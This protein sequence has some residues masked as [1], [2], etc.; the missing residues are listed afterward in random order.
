MSRKAIVFFFVISLSEKVT[1]WIVGSHHSNTC[2]DVETDVH[3]EQTTEK[4][5]QVSVVH[6]WLKSI[7]NQATAP[8]YSPY[9]ETAKYWANKLSRSPSSI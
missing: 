4:M 5:N 3:G 1:P 7:G 8:K 6:M 9:T 2:D